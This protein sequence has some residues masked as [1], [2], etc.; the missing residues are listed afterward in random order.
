MLL[1]LVAFAALIL[2]PLYVIMYFFYIYYLLVTMPLFLVL[3]PLVFIVLYFIYVIIFITLTKI[4]LFFFNKDLKEGKYKIKE[5]NYAVFQFSLNDIF[6][7]M[8]EALL[9]KLLIPKGII[10]DLLFT[11]FGSKKGKGIMFSDPVHDAYL[12]EI[13]NNV[14]IGRYSAITSHFI[15]GDSIYLKGVKIGNNVTIGG[16]VLIGPG[17][18]IEDNV[19]IGANSF[20]KQDTVL[21][22]NSLYVGTPAKFKKKLKPKKK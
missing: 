9:D 2:I 18:V 1:I 16:F 6:T 22:K 4:V 5:L 8:I 3:L 10:S 12:T 13:G 7:R 20:V 14:I 11:L 21:K 19:I 17:V 15:V